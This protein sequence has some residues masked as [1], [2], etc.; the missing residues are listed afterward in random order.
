VPQLKS[1]QIL[2]LCMPLSALAEGVAWDGKTVPITIEVSKGIHVYSKEPRPEEPKHERGSLYGNGDFH[3]AA[4][5]RFK[6]IKLFRE[7]TCR[8]EYAGHDYDL[9]LCPWMLG[10]ADPRA[11][12]FKIVE[13]KSGK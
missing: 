9:S 8:I 12:I 2:A 1:L 11:D 5:Q 7:G 4:G 13:V 6:V 3:I 10:Y